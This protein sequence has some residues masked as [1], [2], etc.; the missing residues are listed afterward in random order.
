MI[1]SFLLLGQSNMAGR[2][3]LGSVPDIVNE[4]IKMLRNGRWQLMTEPINYDRPTAGVGLA[5]SFG[6]CWR[7]ENETDDIGFIGC[8]D[9]GT[10]LDDWAPGGALFDH[11][12]AQAKLAQRTSTLSGILWHQGESDCFPERAEVYEKKFSAI[13]HTLR[14][15]LDVPEVPLV[16]GGLGSFLTTGLYGKY[17]ATY[18]LVNQALI[19]FSESSSNC[20]FVTAEGLTANAD[21]LHFDAA[22]QRIF[23]VRYFEA[24]HMRQHVTRPLE[25][26]QAILDS[27]YRRP[28]NRQERKSV[29]EHQFSGGKITLDEFQRQMA[30]LSSEK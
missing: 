29:I 17:F 15:E 20:Y 3:Y 6:A 14:N 11:A 16:I 18:P 19:K 1:K 21:A 2:G 8:A 28:L 9:G 13:V 12:L 5:S 30:S 22:S 10:S 26:E 27:I 24:F 4:G 23:G 25:N 7:R